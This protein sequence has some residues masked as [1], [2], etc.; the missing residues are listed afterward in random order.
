MNTQ[1]SKKFPGVIH[2]EYTDSEGNS[3]TEY[4]DS[5]GNIHTE[6]TKSQKNTTAYNNG[7]VEG[8][9]AN[10]QRDDTQESRTDKN[11]SKGL[12]I[13]VIVTCVAGLTAGTIYFLTKQN[14]PETAP[15]VIMPTSQTDPKPTQ[16]TPQV[17]VVEKPVVTIVK[18]PVPQ[19]QSDKATVNITTNPPVSNPSAKPAPVAVTPAVKP[20]PVVVI[21]TVKPTPA[22]ETPNIQPAPVAETQTVTKTDSELKAEILKQFKDNLP[23]NQ[24]M[25]DVKNGAVTVSG[26]AT[27]LEQ[28]QQIQPLLE[29]I[30]EIG[31]IDIKAT[32]AST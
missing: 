9:L 17:P 14:N 21:P 2:R 23:N 28:L 27:T 3:Y 20:A 22:V 31:K 16:P 12:L 29:S 4:K 8:N 18:V 7:Y 30:E 10:E 5:K 32:L 26:T 6:Y 15:V 25:V 24:L 11:I 19:D 1:N 13:G